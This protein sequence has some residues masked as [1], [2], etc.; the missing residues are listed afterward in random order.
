[1][2]QKVD[3]RMGQ[4]V[5]SL[6][7]NYIR[8]GGDQMH[9]GDIA[10]SGAA[11]DSQPESGRKSSH[12]GRDSEREQVKRGENSVLTPTRTG[13]PGAAA[14]SAAAGLALVGLVSWAVPAGAH[15]LRNLGTEARSVS[16]NGCTDVQGMVGL[17]TD[18]GTVYQYSASGWD[19][20]YSQCLSVGTRVGG[21]SQWHDGA[22]NHWQQVSEWAYDANTAYSIPPNEY[23]QGVGGYS[24]IW[25][26]H[27]WWHGGTGNAQTDT[28]KW[29]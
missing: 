1:M 2:G 19:H 25:S 24:P 9:I 4:K 14:A 15:T 18:L 13:R 17:D 3:E 11:A 16:A 20:K 5:A 12:T 22:G 28:Y 10:R 26:Q 6:R 7:S 23:M 27:Y 21:T 29:T 8:R